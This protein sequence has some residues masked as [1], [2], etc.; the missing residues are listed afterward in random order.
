[1][2]ILEFQA[3]LEDKMIKVQNVSK[4][5]NSTEVATNALD[6]VS[7]EIKKGE[8]VAI[9][10]PSGSGKSTL[11]HIIGALD[12]P[13]SGKYLINDIDI[14]KM[15]DDELSEIRNKQI[16]FVFQSY[17]LLP[18]IS[19]L[20]N[21]L[22]PMKYAGISNSERIERA[23]EVLKA[24]GLENKMQNN[25]SQ[26]SG[27][28]KQ[29]VAIARALSMKPAIILADEPTGNLPTSQTKEIMDI[30]EKL[31]KE[32]NTIIIITHE[33]AVASRAKRIISIVDGKIVKDNKKKWIFW[34]S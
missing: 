3:Y 20:D 11:M 10:G 33:E 16:G 17:N 25:P 21:V 13:S 12:L 30:F 34:R 19:A 28:Q 14:S 4:I 8:F 15:S 18:R 5:Y 23:Q 9:I 7:F 2:Q 1:M 27:G 29:R 6:D 22:L 26:L 32:G 31:N 24:V